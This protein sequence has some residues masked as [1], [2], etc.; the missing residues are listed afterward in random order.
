VPEASADIDREL[1]ALESELRRLEAEYNM[2][3]AGRLPR[4]PWETRSRVEGM[5]KRL[6]RQHVSNYGTR[7]RFTT[8]QS[9][10]AAFVELWDRSLR[11]KEEGRGGGMVR[12]ATAAAPAPGPAAK[13]DRVLHVTSLSDPSSETAKI[14]ELY[15]SITEA[16]RQAGQPDVPYREFSALV[17]GQ[18]AKLKEQGG[19]EVTFKLS[20]KAGKVSFT[21]RAIK[22][23]PS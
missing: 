20:L 15:D 4:P 5:I 22:A 2:F 21:A 16:R 18:V 23:R 11:S 1:M 19:R 3:F 12:P 10:Y 8:L 9:R 17:E 14:R 7:F 13:A 6:D